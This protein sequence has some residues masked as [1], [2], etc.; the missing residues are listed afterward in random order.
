MRS[1]QVKCCECR[2]YCFIDGELNVMFRCY[3]VKSFYLLV[4]SL[5]K[6]MQER[7]EI[8]IIILLLFFFFFL[9][10]QVVSSINTK[11][12]RTTNTFLLLL[13]SL[14]FLL[15]YI[16]EPNEFSVF[17]TVYLLYQ[18]MKKSQSERDRFL[19]RYNI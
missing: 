19:N 12:V 11:P 10:Q 8:L 14:F 13:F 2:R 7:K 18:K 16:I 9:Q 1:F 4:R 15:S 17:Y 3:P 6:T 5:L